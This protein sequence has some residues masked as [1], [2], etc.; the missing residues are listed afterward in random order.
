[1]TNAIKLVFKFFIIV[2]VINSYGAQMLPKNFTYLK[3]IVPSIQ[4]DIRYFTHNNFIGRPLPGYEDPVCILT[5]PAADALLMVQ[6]ELN[7]DDLGLKV[8]DCYRPQMTVDEFVRW[9]QDINDQK[10]ENRI[11]SEC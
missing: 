10:N 3:N 7:N 2:F 1:M 9:S 4:Q 11:L 8:F 5:Q 6:N